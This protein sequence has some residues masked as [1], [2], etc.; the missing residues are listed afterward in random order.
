MNLDLHANQVIHKKKQIIRRRPDGGSVAGRFAIVFYVNASICRSQDLERSN[1][2]RLEHG[3]KR[4]PTIVPTSAD[5]V[6]IPA[7]LVTYPAVNSAADNAKTIMLATGAGAQPTLTVSGNTLTV[8]GNFTI[9]AGTVTHSGGTISVTAGA[10]SITGTVNETAGTFLCSVGLTVNLGG[11]LNVS[12]TGVIHMASAL[13]TTPTDNIT[14]A[15][16]GT[17]TQS[18]GS[19][20]VRDFS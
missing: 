20:D 16:G 14:I 2:H 11:N 6:T 19:V 8:A 3:W 1:K 4:L 10:V 15:P 17:M 18:C 5:D 7:G 9:N 13:A 12:G